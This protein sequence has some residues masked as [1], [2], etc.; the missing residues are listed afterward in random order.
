MSLLPVPKR[1]RRPFRLGHDR[2]VPLDIYEVVASI[3]CECLRWTA[4][5]RGGRIVWKEKRDG[6]LPAEATGSLPGTE[7]RIVTFQIRRMLGERLNHPCDAAYRLHQAW[8]GR[9]MGDSVVFRH[10]VDQRAS[11]L[12]GAGTNG[13]A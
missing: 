3:L 13:K 1:R 6:R 4:H 11:A 8:R 12:N 2:R 5:K 10:A 7:E 9:K